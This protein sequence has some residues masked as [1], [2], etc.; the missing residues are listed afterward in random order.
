MV[1]G[2]RQIQ[3]E[4][5]RENIIQTAMKLYLENGI[6][7]STDTIARE[8]G[9]SHGALFVHFP[10]RDDLQQHVL[11]RLTQKIGDRLHALSMEGNLR[12]LLLAHL[13]ILEEY[14]NFYTELISK[15]STMPESTANLVISM[16]SVVSHHFS[17][18]MEDEQRTCNFKQIPLHMM[19]N[20]WL[21]LVHYYLLNAAVFAPGESVLKRYKEELADTFMK[22]IS[23]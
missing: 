11:E 7:T 4:M 14:E 16:Q 1:Q 21:G 15:S 18:V 12:A 23:N 2:K 17:K 10:T 9:V 13:Q 5:T 3:K 8:A 19:L 22:L 20:T 6:T